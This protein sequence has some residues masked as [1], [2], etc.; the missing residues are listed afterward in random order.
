MVP[1]S[2]TSNFQPR[3]FQAFD[4]RILRELLASS[5]S[6]L[7]G[8]WHVDTSS[9]LASHRN[10]AGRIP[11]SR[12]SSTSADIGR[13]GDGDQLG[14]LARLDACPSS[15]PKPR[16]SAPCFVALASSAPAGHGGCELAHQP[17]APRTVQILDAREA[18]GADRDPHA[19]RVEPLHRRQAG[20]RP[21]VAARARHDRRAG[22]RQLSAARASVELHAMDGQQP[23]VHQTVAWRCSRP[24]RHAGGRQASFHAPSSFSRPRHAPRPTRRNSISSADSPR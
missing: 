24:D 5:G 8:T 7:V 4:A 19:G 13:H 10:L 1:L 22:G 18:V 20:A 17:Q 2:P 6:W 12:Y 15:S 21:P 16:A 14:A 9:E 23:F 3:N 11:V